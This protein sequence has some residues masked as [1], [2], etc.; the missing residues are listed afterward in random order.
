MSRRPQILDQIQGG[1]AAPIGR[2]PVVG[3]DNSTR[4]D[5]ELAKFAEFTVTVESLF[6]LPGSGYD[7][8]RHRYRASYIRPKS[9]SLRLEARTGLS[10]A[11]RRIVSP[12]VRRPS[13][14][15][16]FATLVAEMDNADGG[17]PGGGGVPMIPDE[18]VAYQWI[19]KE[20]GGKFV[21]SKL[22]QRP[23]SPMQLAVF[24]VPRTGSY[25]ITLR[26]KFKDNRQG[27]RTVRVNIKDWF[28][29]S[30]GDSAASGQG[31]PDRQ[32][33]VSMNDPRGRAI[34]EFSTISV[35]RE[36]HAPMNN[37]PVWTEKLAYR[38]MKS[39]P[40]LAARAV[41]HTFES[42]WDT[43][44]KSKDQLTF[45][46]VVF[47]SFA[48]TGARI[49]RG[50][51]DPQKGKDDFIGAGQLDECERTANGRPI[52]AMMISIGGNDLG[53]ADVLS[54]LVSGDSVFRSGLRFLDS[55]DDAG[56]REKIR[57]RLEDMLE[58]GSDLDKA[59]ARLNARLDELRKDPG[60]KEVYIAGYPSSIFE[61][62]D[63]DGKPRFKACGVFTGPDLD[64]SGE[65]GKAIKRFGTKLNAAIKRNADKHHWHYVD[66]DKDFAGHGYCADESVTFWVSAE[67]SCRRQGDFEGMAHPNHRGHQ[68]YALRL[69][70]SMRQHTFKG[71]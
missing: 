61:V 41:Q 60:L 51:F 6:G 70:Q 69:S 26:A 42:T 62:N 32:G 17:V 57:K 8:K 14:V 4:T 44:G 55:G 5:A 36:Y 9:F 43:D 35:A 38:S 66:V 12:G 65:D 29:V 47:A 59:Y 1:R 11:S 49:D 16:E 68:A 18:L 54:G 13:T 20:R 24:E 53:F 45:N 52:D 34:C 10:A 28:V 30:L 40:A 23:V 50:L 19:V 25:D 3:D 39:G 58:V 46:K 2:P 37:A 64:L 7:S 63:K 48:R 27:E 22:V 21:S 56:E 31:N 15:N 71:A 33:T 67:D